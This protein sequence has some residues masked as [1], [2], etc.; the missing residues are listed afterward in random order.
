MMVSHHGRAADGITD[1]NGNENKVDVHDDAI[2]GNAV[3][4]RQLHELKIVQHCHQ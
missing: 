1:E 4:P 3:L 2:G